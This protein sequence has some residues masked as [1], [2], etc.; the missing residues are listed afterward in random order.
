MESR[1]KNCK[2]WGVG[3][4]GW[5]VPAGMN[6][7]GHPKI[8]D[9]QVVLDGPDSMVILATEHAAPMT[10]PEFGCVHFEPKE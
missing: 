2:H 5:V 3:D 1:C 8:D 9:A 7:C 6:H 10:G 4:E